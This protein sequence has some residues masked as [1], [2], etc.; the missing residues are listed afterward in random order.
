[1]AAQIIVVGGGLSGLSAAHTVL[2]HGA[3]VLVLDKNSFFG[4]NSTKATSGINGA[5]TKTQI[6]L[7]IQD[8]AAIFEADTI[9]SARDL[10]R[11]DIIKVLT[12]N[13]ASAV[14]WLQDKFKLDLSLV[15]RLGG[16]T[17]PRTHRGKEM[18]PGMTITYALMELLEEIAEKQ[19]NRA[20]IVM[21]ARVTKLIKE[22]EEVIG[23]EYEKDGQTF[24]ELG[25]VILATGGYAADFTESSLLKKYRPDIYDLPTTNGDHCTGDGHKMVLAIGGQAIDLEKVQ[26]HP[27]GLVDPKEPDAKIKF[28]AAEALR[29]VGG[30]LLNGEGKRFCDELGHRDYVT[31]E[32]WKTK[33]PVRLVLNSKAAKEIEWHCKHYV[34]RGL[35]RKFSS[36]EDLAREIGVPVSRLRETFDDYNGIASGKKKD[37][38]GKKFFHNAP[39]TVDD[40][41]HV[42]LMAP[43]LHYTMGGVEVTPDSEVKDVQ[44][45]VI[46]G[47]YASGEIA[48]G[49]HGANRLGGSS[50][51]GCVVFGRVAGDSASRQLL[52]NLSSETANRRLGQIAGQLAPYQATV[53]VDPTNQKVRL[54]IFWGQQQGVSAAIT[55]VPSTPAPSNEKKE[56][57]PPVELKEYT[58]DDVAKHSSEQDCWDHPGGKKSILLFAGKDASEE[59]NMLHDKG[60]VQKY[61]PYAKSYASSAAQKEYLNKHLTETDPEVFDIIEKEKRRQRESIVLIPSENFTSRAVMEALGSV[62][63]NKYSEGYPGARYYGG[64]EFI[65][66]A[67]ILCQKR[68]LEAFN[69]KDFEWGVNVQSLSG[70]PANLYVY[71]AIL[72]PH[73][74]LMGLDLPH[75]GHLSHGY[76]TDTKKI[77]AVS[78]YFE[79]LPYRLN[80]KTGIIDYDALEATALLYRPKVIIAGASAYPRK[81]DYA[82]MKKIA[83]KTNSYLMADIAHISG[84]ISAGV[85][86]SPFEFADI[87]TTTTHKSLRGPRGALIFYR[88]GVRKVD[89]KG[90]ETLYELENPINQSVFPGHQGGPHN[91]TITAL[92]VALKQAKSPLFKEY[93]QQVLINSLAFAEA[94]K[95]MGY[96]LVS[97][98][99]D[100]HLLLVDLRSKKIDGARV[101]RVLELANIAANK[102]TVPGDKSALIPGGIRVGTPAMTSRGLTESDFEKV[103]EYI[104]RCVKL[105]INIKEKVTGTKLLD[106]KAYLGD[107]SNE[108]LIKELNEEVVDFAKKFPTIGFDENEMKFK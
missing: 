93:Q 46:P 21:K 45:K 78:S 88:K 76:Q 12:G 43:V 77:S 105:A 84:L 100:T 18:F 71:N 89:K 51:L 31:G 47:L 67:E 53:N 86:P 106:F 70:A 26:V 49:V 27:T 32:I 55:Q 40:N 97:G 98:G 58:I 36:G 9:R 20:R 6:A 42:A 56:A 48:G 90:K 39:L 83:E 65:D 92:A 5:L 59:F 23:V 11:P 4:G 33:G 103:A 38:Y 22:G 81:F 102:N 94:F 2:E 34:G 79:T 24:K 104:D 61:A 62:M 41:F 19:P 87:V 16:H 52:Q 82:R 60:V 66:Q 10:A 80:E 1:M 29:G 107:G 99:T 101:E 72:R 28:L 68:A 13:S 7:G 30:L 3:N 95:K 25:P 37:P 96:N 108:P 91:H 73:E 35:M 54:E 17:Q 14:E 85:L 63:Q 8:S 74:R 64:N 57:A 75:G 44:G 50:L 15:S 69:L